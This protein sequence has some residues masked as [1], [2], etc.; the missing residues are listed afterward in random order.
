MQTACWGAPGA[1]SPA[2]HA[3][4][5]HASLLHAGPSPGTTSPG[6]AQPARLRPHPCP[7][8]AT[9]RGCRGAGPSL[10][11]VPWGLLPSI[12]HWPPLKGL[13][14]GHPARDPPPRRSSRPPRRLLDMRRPPTPPGPR[15]GPP[16]GPC[17]VV[18]GLGCL[19]LPPRSPPR[20]SCP[21][22]DCPHQGPHPLQ[23]PGRGR[24]GRRQ[25]RGAGWG[26]AGQRRGWWEGLIGKA[27]VWEGLRGWPRR[28]AC[29]GESR[30]PPFTCSAQGART[31]EGLPVSADILLSPAPP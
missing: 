12:C 7:C 14:P 25:W 10:A 15:A 6:P 19:L 2:L 22:R 4:R 8:S 9:S 31:T 13:R 20:A 28:S 29:W 17:P 18:S 5:P 11:R 16:A 23:R 1:P 26:Q 3:P 27:W 24:G 21:L 30:G